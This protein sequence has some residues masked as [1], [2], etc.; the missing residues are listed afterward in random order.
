[1]LE[2]KLEEHPLVGEN[3]TQITFSGVTLERRT[4]GHLRQNITTSTEEDHVIPGMEHRVK[5]KVRVFP[6]RTVRAH[7]QGAT[8]WMDAPML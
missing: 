5:G 3:P 1:M 8:H 4:S 7:Q 2:R 6:I